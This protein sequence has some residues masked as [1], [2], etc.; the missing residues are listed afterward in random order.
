M[1]K[2]SQIGELNTCDHNL[3]HTYVRKWIIRQVEKFLSRR[4]LCNG[5]WAR[6]PRAEADVCYDASRE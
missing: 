1:L 6:C 2:E 3:I 4:N 5:K